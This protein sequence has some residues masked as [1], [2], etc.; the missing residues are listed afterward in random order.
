MRRVGAMQIQTSGFARCCSVK[1]DEGRV[2]YLNG[3]HV[4]RGICRDNQGCR[5]A[6][7]WRC[8]I[9]VTWVHTP[10]YYITPWMPSL[11]S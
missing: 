5:Y 8:I 9:S 6:Q 3:D 2:R 10:I 1:S 4:P 11:S 7:R